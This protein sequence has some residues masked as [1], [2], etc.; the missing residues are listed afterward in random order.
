MKLNPT[1]LNGLAGKASTPVQ[2][3]RN[4]STDVQDLAFFALSGKSG[5]NGR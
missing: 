1:F 3:T 2:L 5:R 4:C